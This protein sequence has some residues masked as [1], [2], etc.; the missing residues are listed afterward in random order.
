[1]GFFGLENV[2][3]PTASMVASYVSYAVLQ[4]VAGRKKE[5][6]TLKPTHIQF[7]SLCSSSAR[8]P[9]LVII[10]CGSKQMFSCSNLT[11]F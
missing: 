5:K 6:R 4:A 9:V 2:K 8:E 10:V 11:M 1:M 3:K 7:P